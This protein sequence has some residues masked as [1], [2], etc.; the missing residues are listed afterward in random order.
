M[1]PL[2]GAHALVV[3]LELGLDL[4]CD[5]VEVGRPLLRAQPEA[6]LRGVG[7]FRVELLSVLNGRTTNAH[8][9]RVHVP[10]TQSTAAT[11]TKALTRRKP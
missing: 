7:V 10:R 6:L 3:L 5:F 11:A 8:R 1:Q 4:L 2:H 9:K